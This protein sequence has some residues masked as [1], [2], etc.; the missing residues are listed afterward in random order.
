MKACTRC[1]R[2]APMLPT[3]AEAERRHMILPSHYACICGSVQKF[4]DGPAAARR[5]RWR[6]WGGVTM[7]TWTKSKANTGIW[8][9]ESISRLPGPMTV[10]H[11]YTEADADAIIEQREFWLANHDKIKADARVVPPSA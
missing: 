10:A 4:K 11:A 9:I 5:E 2:A 8:A 3:K 7:E 6:R 1:G